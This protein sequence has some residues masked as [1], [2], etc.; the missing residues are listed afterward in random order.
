MTRNENLKIQINRHGRMHGLLRCDRV[1]RVKIS[2]YGLKDLAAATGSQ[3][4]TLSC[5]W[6]IMQYDGGR[7]F[8]LASNKLKAW[9]SPAAPP[10]RSHMGPAEAASPNCISNLTVAAAPHSSCALA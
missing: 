6:P 7:A 3:V 1:E 4:P 5:S 9:T 10:C 8:C 2:R